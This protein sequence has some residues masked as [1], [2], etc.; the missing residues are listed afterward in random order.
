MRYRD[1]DINNK[2]WK[3]KLSIICN[4]KEIEFDDLEELKL[5]IDDLYIA[6][7]KGDKTVKIVW[8]VKKE[9]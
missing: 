1:Y 5:F 7:S 8:D 2:W 9:K 6:S 3:K 4:G